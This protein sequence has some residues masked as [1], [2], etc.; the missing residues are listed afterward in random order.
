MGFNVIFPCEIFF[1]SFYF[2]QK[3]K[4]NSIRARLMHSCKNMI[5]SEYLKGKKYIRR[6]LHFRVSPFEQVLNVPFVISE[7]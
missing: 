7:K 4:K 5:T 1:K 3:R 2:W 6:K